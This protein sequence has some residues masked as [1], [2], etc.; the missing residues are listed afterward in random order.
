MVDPLD[1]GIDLCHLP[2]SALAF[3]VE[4]PSS[5]DAQSQERQRP[6]DADDVQEHESQERDRQDPCFDAPESFGQFVPHEQLLPFDQELALGIFEQMLLMI[7]RLGAAL[8]HKGAPEFR[9]IAEPIRGVV[10]SFSRREGRDD[11][12]VES[13]KSG[14]VVVLSGWGGGRP[15]VVRDAAADLRDGGSLSSALESAGDMPRDR[16]FDRC[17]CPVARHHQLPSPL[18][19]QTSRTSGQYA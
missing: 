19:C 4:I 11:P 14:R 16:C 18:A 15:K 9:D 8:P 1:Q 17:S 2:E 3:S 13:N 12:T 7:Y 6:E 10:C 5:A